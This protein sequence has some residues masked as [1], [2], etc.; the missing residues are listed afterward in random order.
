MVFQAVGCRREIASLLIDDVRVL[1]KDGDHHLL[2]WHTFPFQHTP[3]GLIDHLEHQ[4]DIV[5]ELSQQ[6]RRLLVER[7]FLQGSPRTAL[8]PGG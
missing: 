4:L 5:F 3:F 1:L 6:Y 8:R 7:D 2:S